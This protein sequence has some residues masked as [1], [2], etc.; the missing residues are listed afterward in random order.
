[1]VFPPHLGLSLKPDRPGPSPRLFLCCLT[2]PPWVLFFSM[3]SAVRCS[4]CGDF[5]HAPIRQEARCSISLSTVDCL[6]RCTEVAGRIQITLHPY[7]SYCFLY[8]PAPEL[9]KKDVVSHLCF[10]KPG[11]SN[12][13][14][15]WLPLTA[16]AVGSR[17]AYKGLS[18]SL[19]YVL[20]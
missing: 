20:H 2:F 12:S 3:L 15:I 16:T 9:E 11:F 6:I 4:S 1:M 8:L 7:N 19:S 13:I 17:L 10:W 18:L 5:Y 14:L